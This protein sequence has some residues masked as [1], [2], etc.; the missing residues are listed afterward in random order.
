M[1]MSDSTALLIESAM[2]THDVDIAEHIIVGAGPAATFAAAPE[3]DL[4]TVHSAL[5]D[6][7]M[8]LRA[9]RPGPEVRLRH[10][11]A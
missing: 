3:L 7:S 8:W 1:T 5:L 6:L 11:M 10:R 4:L 2:P 9:C